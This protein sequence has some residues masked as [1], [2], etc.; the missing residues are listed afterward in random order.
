M[1]INDL[2]FTTRS[3]ITSPEVCAKVKIETAKISKTEVQNLLTLS[4]IFESPYI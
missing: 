2:A 4:G 1:A 3:R